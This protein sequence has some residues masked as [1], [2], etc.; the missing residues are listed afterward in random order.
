MLNNKKIPMLRDVN[1]EYVFIGINNVKTE[2]K[3]II[4]QINITYIKFFC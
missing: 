2:R 3:Q 1:F 4:I